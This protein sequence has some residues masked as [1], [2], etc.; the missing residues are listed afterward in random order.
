LTR[1]HGAVEEKD[2]VDFMEGQADQNYICFKEYLDFL[3]EIAERFPEFN[4]V[5][6][7]HPSENSSAW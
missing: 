3:P 2:I 6:R 7:P 1:D 5:I 4:F